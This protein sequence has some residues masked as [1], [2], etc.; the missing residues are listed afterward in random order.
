[1]SKTA[2]TPREKRQKVRIANLEKE[3]QKG[4]AEWEKEADEHRKTK[5]KALEEAPSLNAV[6][7][8]RAAAVPVVFAGRGFQQAGNTDF[9]VLLKSCNK[10]ANFILTG[11]VYA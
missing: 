6:Q 10:I 2:Y 3:R 11:N 1:M 5:R 7:Q 4:Y 8:A 9:T